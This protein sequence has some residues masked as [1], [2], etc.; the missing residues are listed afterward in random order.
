MFHIEIE[1]SECDNMWAHRLT[2]SNIRVNAI[3]PGYIRTEMNSEFFDSEASLC[4]HTFSDADNNFPV[5]NV[6]Y[7]RCI[8]LLWKMGG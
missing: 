2:R 7:L 1:L 5:G 4:G 8:K 3:C 6:P